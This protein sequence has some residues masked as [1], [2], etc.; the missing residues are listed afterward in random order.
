MHCPVP[1]AETVD[2][3]RTFP[4]DSNLKII[5]LKQIFKG[6]NGFLCIRYAHANGFL[7]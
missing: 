4:V 1:L 2:G 5:R 3:G 7:A 6:L